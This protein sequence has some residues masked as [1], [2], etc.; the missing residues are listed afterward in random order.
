MRIIH[1]EHIK[2]A[3]D[4]RTTRLWSLVPALFQKLVSSDKLFQ[5]SLTA[6]ANRKFLSNFFHFEINEFASFVLHTMKKKFDCCFFTLLSTFVRLREIQE[7]KHF[8]IGRIPR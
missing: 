7:D 5:N 2:L 6:I 4:H 1:L 8:E 3:F